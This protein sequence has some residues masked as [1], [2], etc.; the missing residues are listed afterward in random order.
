MTTL[1]N[2]PPPFTTTPSLQESFRKAA[3]VHDLASHHY[4]EAARLHDTGDHAAARVHANLAEDHAVAALD[5]GA[6]TFGS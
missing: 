4:H 6:V 1:P 5:A 2:T 3:K